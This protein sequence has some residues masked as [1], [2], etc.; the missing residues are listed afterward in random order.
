[1]KFGN[2]M[3]VLEIRD[4]AVECGLILHAEHIYQDTFSEENCFSEEKK[5]KVGCLF[6]FVIILCINNHVVCI[7]VTATVL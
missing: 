4:R 3:N 1:M 6:I 7:F 2:R 5:S